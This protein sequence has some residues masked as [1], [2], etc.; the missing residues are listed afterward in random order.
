[1]LHTCGELAKKVGH[2]GHVRFANGILRSHLRT[3]TGTDDQSA[4]KL[5]QT[6][7]R[8]A[9]VINDE[10]EQTSTSKLATSYSMPVWIVERWLKHFGE[11]Q[12]IALLQQAQQPGRLVLRTCPLAITVDGL[13]EILSK[14]GIRVTSSDLVK[15]CLIVQTDA[16]A[17]GKKFRGAPQEL[18]G[19]SEGLFSIQDES[20]AFVSIVLDPKPG[21]LVVDLCAGAGGKTTHISELMNNQ[22]QIIAVDQSVKRLELIKENR[23][24]LGLTNIKLLNSDARHVSLEAPADCVLLDAPCMGTGVLSKRPDL[25]YHRQL[26]DIGKLVILQR[27]LL[28]SAAALTKSGGVLVYSTCSIEPEENIENMEWFLASHK[29][30]SASDLSGYIPKAQLEKWVMAEEKQLGQQTIKTNARSG[31]IQ[32]L[33]SLH[34]VSGFFIG[35]MVKT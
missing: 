35:R 16:K 34:G 28:A 5:S 4:N 15:G 3:K 6:P 24:R 31:F 26:A 29:Q 22:G 27:E 25:R 7:D 13:Q 32:L 19:Y 10:R 11:A 21:Q 9:T 33:P 17:K 14:S 1:V 2:T 12:T 20:S 18:P 30:F 8:Q 23:R